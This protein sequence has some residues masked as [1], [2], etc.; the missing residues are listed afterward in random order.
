MIGA[1]HPRNGGR[2]SAAPSP[3]TGPSAFRWFGD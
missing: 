3:A 1:H 2:V